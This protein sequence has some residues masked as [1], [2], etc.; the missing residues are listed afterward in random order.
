[1]DCSSTSL[2]AFDR[3]LLVVAAP[4]GPETRG[5]VSKAVMEALGPEGSVVNIARGSVIDEPAMI[6][7]LKSGKL[8]AAGL[9]RREIGHFMILTSNRA[10]RPPSPHSVPTTPPGSMASR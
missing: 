1:M 9:D 8:G 4:G 2:S 10:F 7:A 6:E 5:L 3:S